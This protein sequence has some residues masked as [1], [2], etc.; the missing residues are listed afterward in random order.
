MSHSFAFTH[1]FSALRMRSRLLS[2][3]IV[4]VFFVA[5]AGAHAQFGVSSPGTQVHDASP[6]KPPAGARVAMVEF[7]DFECPLC[8][9]HNSILK[10]AVS[11]YKIP[12]IR[13]DFPL[14]YHAW[15]I[16]AAVNARWF[17]LHSKTLGDEYRDA[18]FANQ[19]SIYSPGVLRQFTAKFASS[20]HLA[21]P[22][23]IDPQ[24]RLAAAVKAD[25]ALG[26]RVGID[27]TP[28]VFIVTSGGKGAHYVEVIRIDQDLYRIIDQ[29]I[30][31]TSSSKPSVP[32]RASHRK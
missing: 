25:K 4:V 20:H 7:A 17:D 29:A 18:V 24:G 9:A 5:A 6:L 12:W 15:A 31:D 32:R 30:A 14:P 28:T 3:L 10:A 19:S 16:D 13:H 23:A 1:Y 22:F 8:G 27:H 26:E 2:S 11:R 21:L